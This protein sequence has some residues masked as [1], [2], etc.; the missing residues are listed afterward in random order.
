[1]TIYKFRYV[2]VI[3]S[4]VAK[5]TQIRYGTFAYVTQGICVYIAYSNQISVPSTSNMSIEA[6]ILFLSPDWSGVK[7]ILKTRFSMNGKKTI[8]GITPLKY[9]YATYPNETAM[10]A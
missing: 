5:V 6:S 7:A 9:K 10:T 1:V 2:I 4:T 3:W 8:K